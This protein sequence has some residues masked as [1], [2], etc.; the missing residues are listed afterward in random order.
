MHD[1]ASQLLTCARN[2]QSVRLVSVEGGFC[3]V[4][5][6]F[7]L[8]N[9]VFRTAG[10]VGCMLSRAD[11]G[12]DAPSRQGGLKLPALPLFTLPTSCYVDLAHWGRGRYMVPYVAS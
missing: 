9:S 1:A 10:P 2:S 5:V 6:L 4:F 7:L 11:G 12:L 3:F 8:P